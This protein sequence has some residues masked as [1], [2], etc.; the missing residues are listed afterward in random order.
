MRHASML[1]DKLEPVS[2]SRMMVGLM[3]QEAAAIS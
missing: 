2:E 3:P 1:S